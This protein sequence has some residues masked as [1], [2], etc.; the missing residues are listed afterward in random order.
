M[1]WAKSV[2]RSGRRLRVR[3]VR[4]LAFTF[5]IACLASLF[6]S[7]GSSVKY[8]ETGVG[9]LLPVELSDGSRISINTDSSV[10]MSSDGMTL[11][12]QISR[13]EALFNL[14]PNPRRHLVVS[15]G[16]LDIADRGT[17]FGVRVIDGGSVRV[18]VEAGQV[19][20]SAGRAVGA[21]VRQNQQ[22]TVDYQGA[23]PR[24]S[25]Q[26]VAPEDIQ[27][28]VSWVGGELVFRDERLA[29]A[30]GEINRYNLTQVEVMDRAVGEKR[31]GGSF[32]TTD[33]FAFA[34]SITTL[35]PGIRW[36]CEQGARGVLVLRLYGTQ[37]QQGV[38]SGRPGCVSVTIPGS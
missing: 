22:A 18:T 38:G 20:L 8:F 16:G 27:R 5:L 2:P 25:I 33:P 37:A 14:R 35:Y 4:S 12:V 34:K 3:R 19:Q 15:V 9:E 17:V 29:E 28:Q 10:K 36:A 1:R 24:V 30:V 26:K 13:G 11:Y 32:S 31:I 21:W 6:V 23:G 7:D